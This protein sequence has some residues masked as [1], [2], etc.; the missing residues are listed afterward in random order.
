MAININTTA[1]SAFSDLLSLALQMGSQEQERKWRSG[2]AEKERLSRE[3]AAEKERA[4][5]EFYNSY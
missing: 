4:L 1:A 5:G 2:E 3:T